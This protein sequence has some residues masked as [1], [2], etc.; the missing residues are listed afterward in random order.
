MRLELEEFQKEMKS[1]ET[2]FAMWLIQEARNVPQAMDM[3]EETTEY[4]L[5]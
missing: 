1:I 5:S 4:Y 2:Q 3:E